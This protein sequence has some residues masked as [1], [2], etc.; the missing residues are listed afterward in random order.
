MVA[1]AYNLSTL[2]KEAERSGV[3]EWLEDKTYLWPAWAIWVR[4]RGGRREVEDSK[5]DG[6]V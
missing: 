6:K 4:V 3:Q 1:H 2:Q 5:S